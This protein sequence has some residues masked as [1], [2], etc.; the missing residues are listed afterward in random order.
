MGL[1][2]LISSSLIAGIV[3][4]MVLIAC[5][6][7]MKRRKLARQ[8]ARQMAEPSLQSDPE[9]EEQGYKISN[10]GWRVQDSEDGLRLSSLYG[11][12]SRLWSPFNRLAARCYTIGHPAPATDCECGIYSVDNI[13]YS[14]GSVIGTISCWGKVVIHAMGARS[15]YAYP[16]TIDGIRCDMCR[17]IVADL[18]GVK[19]YSIPSYYLFY[20]SACFNPKWHSARFALPASL[21]IDELQRVYGLEEETADVRNR[22]E[23]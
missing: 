10:R 9:S 12:G 6:E 16:R 17:N 3:L 15:Q 20:C 19:V 22:N 8:M 18:S 11:S 21:I 4:G 14:S 23:D 5:D 2:M 13:A 1:V 7:W